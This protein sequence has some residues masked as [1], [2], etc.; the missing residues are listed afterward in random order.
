MKV[1]IVVA[2]LVEFSLVKNILED[3]VDCGTYVKGRIG[4][5][6]VVLMQS[7]IG[8]VNAAS[9]LTF[10]IEREHPDCIINTGVAGGIGDGMHQG[11]I[12]VG[13]EVAYHD[14]WCGEGEWGQVQGFPL[15][16]KASDTLLAAVRKIATHKVR[17]GLICTGDQFIQDFET[18]RS[19]RRRFDDG[20]ACDMESTAFAQVCYIYNVPFMAIRIVS[21]TP[22]MEKDNLCQ[23]K[24]FFEEAPRETF[25]MV[26]ALI[27]EL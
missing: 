18:L 2:L 19:I 17:Y 13:T 4:N 15:R 16:F 21:D 11:D 12:V 22:G 20:L 25:E 8:K 24:N 6:E 10:L 27:G 14:V 23:Y 9:R 3:P 5:C 1:G 26:K 7:G